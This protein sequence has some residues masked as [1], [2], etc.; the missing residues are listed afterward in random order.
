MLGG[1]EATKKWPPAVPNTTGAMTEEEKRLIGQ[2]L[3]DSALVLIGPT[4][5]DWI[6]VSVVPNRQT[7]FWRGD[8]GSWMGTIVVT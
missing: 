3:A 7:L 2:A 8:D 1:Y 6:Q 4:Y 5:V